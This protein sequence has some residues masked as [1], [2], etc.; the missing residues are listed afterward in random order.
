MWMAHSNA[1]PQR[2]GLIA[3]SWSGRC[4]GI[5]AAERCGRCVGEMVRS[6]Y[7]PGLAMP[8]RP[9]HNS[10]ANPQIRR[11]VTTW[12]GGLSRDWQQAFIY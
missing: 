9:L 1:R 6:A 4:T 11:R 8:D 7:V 2:R 3:T 10:T 12:T 5:F